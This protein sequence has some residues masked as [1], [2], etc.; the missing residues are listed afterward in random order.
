[1]DDHH[2]SDRFAELSA[3]MQ[4]LE[5]RAAILDCIANH[6]RGCDRHDH[7]LL[8]SCYHFDG[9]DLHGATRTAGPEY[10]DWANGVH[11]ASSA[12][13]LHH[14]TT[15]TLDI[16]GDTA[17]AESYVIVMLLSTDRK[18]TT[19]MSGRYLDRLER[20]DGEW[21]IAVRVATVETAFNADSSMLESK[22]FTRQGYVHGTRDRSDPSYRR[23]LTADVDTPTW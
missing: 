9:I 12:H 8:R 11:A 10:A 23:P 15:H 22:F 21:R 16:D 5:D 4:V 1:M 19:V 3:R 6:A 13:H 20:R 18:S 7:D 14:L 2:R 17:H